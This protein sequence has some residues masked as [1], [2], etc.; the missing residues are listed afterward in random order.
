MHQ[1]TAPML[2]AF[3]V[4]GYAPFLGLQGEASYLSRGSDELELDYLQFALLG[5]LGG[6]TT[7]T[8]P[9]ESVIPKIF[10]G[11][12]VSHLLSGHGSAAESSDVSLIF[13]AG[14][15]IRFGPRR[16]LTV[17]YR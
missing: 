12:G 3:I 6:I 16:R 15:D 2:G 17:D 10:G 5:R 7:P 9:Q 11:F 4:F 14:A 1:R 8:D 13:G